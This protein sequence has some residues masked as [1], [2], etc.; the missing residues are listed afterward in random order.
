MRAQPVL[1]KI[2]KDLEV[3][4]HEFNEIRVRQKEQ[5]RSLIREINVL[6][7]LEELDTFMNSLL[8][9]CDHNYGTL[10][11]V[12]QQLFKDVAQAISAQKTK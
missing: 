3:K 10:K 6:E 9:W 5:E 12:Y 8:N 1:G 2:C 7:P 11:S 4:E